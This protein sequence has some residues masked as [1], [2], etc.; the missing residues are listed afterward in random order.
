MAVKIYDSIRGLIFLFLVGAAGGC[1]TTAENIRATGDWEQART[2]ES[3]SVVFGR[4][5]WL[6]NGEEKK[7][8]SGMFEFHV[9][10]GLLHLTD[11]TRHFGD[12][13][14]NGEFAWVLEPGMY[15]IFRINYRDPWSGNYFFVPKA[16]FQVPEK[17]KVYYVGKLKVDFAPKRVN[18]SPPA[19]PPATSA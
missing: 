18:T 14:E 3:A 6:E 13:D 5:Q 9:R 1:A 15:A 19:R 2:T 17:G 8:G 7:I 16:G 4:I 11:K 12:V 10:P